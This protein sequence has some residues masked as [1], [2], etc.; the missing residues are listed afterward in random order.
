MKRNWK[1]LKELKQNQIAPD[2]VIITLELKHMVVGASFFIPCLDT[3][4]TM[5]EVSK[6]FK[7]KGWKATSK[8]TIENDLFGLRI[9]RTV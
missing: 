5:R 6:V 3:D 2:G 4:T 8:I 9:W 1:P 7:K